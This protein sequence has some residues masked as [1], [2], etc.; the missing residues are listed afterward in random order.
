MAGSLYQS[1][2][3]IA[4]VAAALGGSARRFNVDAVAECDSTNS[5]LLALA[6]TGAASGSVLVADR[7]TAGRGRRGHTWHSAPDDSL[8][9]SVL[10][11]FGPASSAPTALSLAVGVAVA[12]AMDNLRIDGVTLKWPNDVLHTGRKLAGIL[13]ELQ[14]GNARSAVIGIGLNLRLPQNLPAD[15]AQT[16][17]GLDS[18]GSRTS[19]EE[20]LA[21][22]LASLAHT[23]D[24]YAAGGF[25]A[26]REAWLSRHAFQDQSVR[27]TR[28]GVDSVGTCLGIDQDGALL[29]ATASGLKKIIGGEV[30]LRA[31]AGTQ[32]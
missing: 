21:I 6:E 30:S 23:L 25:A 15:V 5:R 29:V 13:V 9:F 32:P 20:T 3:N 7:Q 14:P 27:I 24:S 10:W 28:D 2:L 26:L 16:A 8:T 19:R 1:S 4:A 12:D 22:I 11:R 17:V 18:L 31:A